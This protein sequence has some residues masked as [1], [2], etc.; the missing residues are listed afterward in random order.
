M[1]SGFYYEHL[2]RWLKEFTSKQ[3]VIIDADKFMS[4]THEY[5]IRI[6]KFFQLENVID[7][8][9]SLLRNK[10]TSML[11]LIE[12]SAEKCFDQIDYTN[13][14][15]IDQE[16]YSFLKQ[17]YFASNKILASLLYQNGYEI[18]LWLNYL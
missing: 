14:N 16:S 5:L 1:Y 15:S 3:L 8:S 17:F 4:N 12:G 7:Y 18:P 13:K 10:E 11:C 2:E 9:Q 6:Q